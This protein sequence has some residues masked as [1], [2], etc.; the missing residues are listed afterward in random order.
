MAGGA[1]RDILCHIVPNDIDFASDAKPDEMITILSDKPDIRL[2]TT[3]SG[4]KH[5][6]V[7]ARIRDTSQYEITTL[8]IDR[9][10]DGRHAEVEFIN[11]WKLGCFIQINHFHN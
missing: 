3:T 4:T 8:R 11:D 7:T 9:N 10:T 6:T 5:G 2:I 1:V